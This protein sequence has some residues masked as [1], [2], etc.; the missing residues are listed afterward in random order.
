MTKKTTLD[1]RP[2]AAVS[3]AGK[4]R[5]DGRVRVD[6]RT[7]HGAPGGWFKPGAGKTEWFRD[8]E[9]G[10]EMVVV[11]A[12]SFTMGSP[13]HE[14]GHYADE[15]PQHKVTIARL[16]AVGRHA[17]TRGQFAAFVNDTNYKMDGGAKVWTEVDWKVDPKASWRNPGFQQDDSHP[18]VCVNWDDGNAF[19]SWLSG[20]SGK[21]YRL[22]TEAEWE[23]VARAGTTTPYWWGSSIHTTRANYDGTKWT[24]IQT[25]IGNY[26]YGGGTKGEWRKS[27]VPVGSFGPKSWGLFNVH[28]NVFEWCEDVYHANYNGAPADGSAWLEGGDVSDRMVRGGS[29]MSPFPS[30][31]RSAS[32]RWDTTDIRCIDLGFRLARTLHP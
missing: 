12:G 4:Y 2:S 28:G 24:G 13:E 30:Y 3:P 1:A 6:A 31:L 10:P 23:Y 11:P 22:L 18:V 26:T 16:F 25:F 5:A 20:Q 19:A 32:R 15:R 8:Y 7:V 17:I 27:T 29:W 21:T 9:A 14:V